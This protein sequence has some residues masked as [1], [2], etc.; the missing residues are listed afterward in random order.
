MFNIL[1]SKNKKES[2][3][4]KEL[5]KEIYEKREF[6][7]GAV[8]GAN[9]TEEEFNARKIAFS[10]KYPCFQDYYIL[11]N[12][13]CYGFEFYS[14]DTAPDAR[15]R[16]KEAK[17]KAKP[18]LEGRGIIGNCFSDEITNFSSEDFVFHYLEVELFEKK[19]MDGAM[20]EYMYD[21]FYDLLSTTNTCSFYE[22]YTSEDKYDDET[23]FVC[24]NEKFGAIYF[25][26]K[27]LIEKLERLK[28]ET[29]Y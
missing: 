2:D 9:E 18:T 4:F 24:N 16:P 15:K 23:I 3:N 8:A 19:D 6:V 12:G 1:A 5:I 20:H 29:G 28:N 13:L 14:S 27:Y 17:A 22:Y 10:K 11:S 26:K 21:E 7:E 25:E